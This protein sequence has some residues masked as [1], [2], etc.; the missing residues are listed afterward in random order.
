MELP[1]WGKILLLCGQIFLGTFH[2][3][4]VHGSKSA[5]KAEPGGPSGNTYR[6]SSALVVLLSEVMKILFSCCALLWVAMDSPEGMQATRAQVR[7]ALVPRRWLRFAL[8]AIVYM[9]ENH[10]RFAVLKELSSPVTWVVFSH[11]EIPIVAVMTTFVLHRPLTPSQWVSVILL[12]D[13][14]KKEDEKKSGKGAKDWD[15]APAADGH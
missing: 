2:V 9:V 15:M 7:A 12:V 5:A 1:P 3:I 4:L 10:I 11:M 8:P 6:Y 14:R 13:E